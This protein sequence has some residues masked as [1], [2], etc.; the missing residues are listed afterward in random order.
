MEKVHFGNSLPLPPIIGLL[1][2]RR[3][4]VKSMVASIKNHTGQTNYTDHEISL[5]LYKQLISGWGFNNNPAEVDLLL[6]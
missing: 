5:V 2:L 4:F 6:C 3:A 1:F